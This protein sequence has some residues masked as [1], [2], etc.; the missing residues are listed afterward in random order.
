MNASRTASAEA[1]ERRRLLLVLVTVAAVG[2]LLLAGLGY[3]VAR[4]VAPASPAGA[5][6]VPTSV[7]PSAT[8]Q[9]AGATVADREGIAAAPMPAV[10]PADARP[11][12][13]GT[14][15]APTS[16]AVSA[17]V[18]PSPTRTGP[19]GVATG[20]PHTAEGAVGQL[21]AIESSVLQ[22]MSLAHARE[23]HRGWALPGAVAAADW[24]LVA[25]VQAFLDASQM[26]GEK[27]PATVVVATPAS[28][29][30]KGFDGPDWVLGCVLMQVR[31]TITTE[32]RMGYGHCD[33]LQWAKGRWMVAPGAEPALA[34]STWPGSP[35][36]VRA[37]WRPW[38][39]GV[40]R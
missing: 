33:R 30:V 17:I 13:S 7:T 5:A 14:A 21:A 31:A 11:P 2:S 22:T 1:W 32:A 6:A 19:A 15:S 18:V 37:G 35:A 16:A 29:L 40:E 39:T 9:P 24:A 25:D 38:V 8:L 27:D 4:T 26:G 34:P 20:F 23:V 10:D 12:G 36:S 28:G 3:T